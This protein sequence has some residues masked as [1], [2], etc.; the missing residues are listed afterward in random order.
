[1]VYY[2]A[3]IFKTVRDLVEIMITPTQQALREGDS[4]NEG[5]P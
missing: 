5:E 4:V 3:S 1:M 2:K